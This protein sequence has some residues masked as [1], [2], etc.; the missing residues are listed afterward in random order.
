MAP[1]STVQ[2]VGGGLRGW[3]WCRWLEVIKSC[4]LEGTSC[5]LVQTRL[6]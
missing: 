4:S 3:R 2:E 6:L 1:T 5:S